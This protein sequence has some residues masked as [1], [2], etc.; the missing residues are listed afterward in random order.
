MPQPSSDRPVSL[1]VPTA[2]GEAVCP[3]CGKT[4]EKPVILTRDANLCPDCRNTYKDMAYVYCLK[5]RK[6]VTRLNPGMSAKGYLVKPNEVLH[7]RECPRCCPGV[8]QSI[9]VE[10][11]RE[12]MFRRNLEVKDK[13]RIGWY[14]Y[15]PGSKNHKNETS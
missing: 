12:E 14:E 9:P 2:A 3:T 11:D 8:I 13:E 1:L 7:V 15:G 10:F 6:V 4:F 5:C